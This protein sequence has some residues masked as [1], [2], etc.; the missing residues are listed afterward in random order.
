MIN[1]KKLE[2]ER[3]NAFFYYSVQ[4]LKR[5]NRTLTNSIMNANNQFTSS[6]W[7]YES[8]KKY[9]E[10]WKKLSKMSKRK[11]MFLMTKTSNKIIKRV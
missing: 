8:F 6:N 7:K 2:N 10:K 1:K 9:S 4:R 5:Q 11:N 3:E